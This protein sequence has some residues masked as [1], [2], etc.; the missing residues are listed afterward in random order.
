[1][2]VR[3]DP[4]PA[5]V[6]L[7]GASAVGCLLALGGLFVTAI[8]TDA[9]W[10]DAIWAG[11]WWNTAAWLLTGVGAVAAAYALLTAMKLNHNRRRVVI[12][13]AIEMLVGAAWIG[14]GFL[15]VS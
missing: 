9:G 15:A 12:A 4:G 14:L 2:S 6:S 11:R 8:E 5:G 3:S 7:L 13:L 1:M 10:G